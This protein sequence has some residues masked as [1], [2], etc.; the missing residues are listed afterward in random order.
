MKTNHI[1]NYP[2]NSEMK[3][4]AKISLFLTLGLL[5]IFT[6][7]CKKDSTDMNFELLTSSVWYRT[8]QCGAPVDDKWNF[9]IFKPDGESCGEFY[10]FFSLNWSL[11]DNGKTLVIDQDEYRIEELTSTTLK[12]AGGCPISFTAKSANVT[13]D[14][15]SA[16]TKTSA[17]L[18]GSVATI[19]SAVVSFEYGISSSY[20][21]TV[22]PVNS[23]VPDN[24]YTLI[25]CPFSGLLP[26][27]TYHCRIKAVNSSGTFYSKDFTFRTCIEQTVSDLD[28][29]IYTAVTI[30]TQIWMTENL[31]STNYS[32][33]DL[34]GTTDPVTLNIQGETSPK[35]QWAYGGNESN[36]A[37]YGR[38][39]TW[40]AA[41]DSRN[42][43]PT[44]WHVA[45]DA[46]WEKLTSATWVEGA[47]GTGSKIK[48]Y[49]T[50]HWK[51]TNIGSTNESGF[52][53]LPCGV[54]SSDGT[55][56]QNDTLWAYW[57]SP[58]Y[59]TDVISYWYL[60]WDIGNAFLR[61]GQKVDIGKDGWSVRC[62]KD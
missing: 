3:N 15:V 59:E 33:G 51:P 39:Y 53:A 38:L 19:T 20:G 46:D 11:I 29:N 27:T 43:C 47:W 14:G 24:S 22:T 5:L 56:S 9:T 13:V 40:Y 35:Y 57:L 10:G 28:G 4:R 12:I 23:S 16:L 54:R 61:T 21:S 30:G 34:I 52:T 1:C 2:E 36:V 26:Q 31:K 50:S 48:E 25:E 41:T 32:N 8:Q 60:V 55:F 18:H 17:N 37:T 62:V 58:T 45:S 42:V 7:R 49:G 44:G 6:S